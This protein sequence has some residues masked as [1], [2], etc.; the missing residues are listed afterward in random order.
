LLSNEF[1]IFDPR[2]SIHKDDILFAPSMFYRLVKPLLFRLDAERA[3]GLATGLL[4]LA[5]GFPLAP[6]LLQAL[7][8]YDDPILATT[9]AGLRFANPVGLAAGFDKRAALIGPLALL[10]FGHIE[11]GTVTP[12]PQ[13]GNP[14]PRLFR[15]PQDRALIN[16]LGFNSPGMLAVALHLRDHRPPTT[17]STSSLPGAQSSVVG[18]RSLVVVGV[19]IGKN[20][21]TPLECAAEDY[22]AAF[23]AL[24]P[25]AD[26]VAINISSPN[27]PGLRQLHER[28]ALEA[29]LGALAAANRRLMRPR[30]LF[31]KIS[32]DETP[33][34]IE[35]VV[36]AGCDA[37]IAGFIATNTT[38][39]RTGLRSPLA[40]EAGGLSGRPLA[41]LA[42]DTTARIH[43]IA[44][45]HAPVIGVGGIAS[46]AEAYARIRAGASLIQ[47]YS[48]LVYDGPG[49][50][51]A[52]NQGLA[53]LLR[54]DGFTTIAE[55]VG[56]RLP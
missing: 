30:P 18:R 56:T 19:N 3:H 42:C 53:R 34:Q 29:L 22:L 46:A 40:A 23:V 24:A 47:L 20:R 27:T 14:R 39:A 1:P 35:E 32:P 13:P 5:A 26:Y 45:G 17:E 49:L 12:R 21:D 10:G 55:A 16:R 2:S 31:L 11:V 38:L 7:F 50:V 9:C 15:L 41:A 28:A 37:G 52:I 36:R 33:T 4:R 44:G 6:Q 48:G 54:R 51:R 8:S 43:Q 25:L